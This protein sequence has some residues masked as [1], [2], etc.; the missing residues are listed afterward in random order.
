ML[1][2]RSILSV[3]MLALSAGAAAQTAVERHARHPGP[4]STVSSNTECRAG[5]HGNPSGCQESYA[6]A[7]IAAAPGMRLYKD[8]LTMSKSW[9][10]ADTTGLASEPGWLYTYIPVGDPRPVSITVRPDVT[11]CVGRDGHRQSRTHYEWTAVQGPFE[12]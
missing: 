7:V 5:C 3:L 4:D 1:I 9:P 12:P 2:P 6:A 11:T 8:S 10:G